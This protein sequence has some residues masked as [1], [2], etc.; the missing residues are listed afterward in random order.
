[1]SWSLPSRARVCAQGLVVALAAAA[2]LTALAAPASAAVALHAQ[3]RHNIAPRPN[4]MVPCVEQG[5]QSDAC[6]SESVAA[7]EH[8]R[9]REGLPDPALHL[10]RGYRSLTRAEQ[11]FV[12]IN[13]ERVD[14]GLRPI[15]GMVPSLDH[16]ATLAAVAGVDP[17]PAVAFLR[18]LGVHRYRS[19]FARDYGALA[20]DY[21]WLYYDGFSSGAMQNVFCAYP[22]AA[23]C[24]SHRAGILDPFDGLP[25][26]LAGAGA[27]PGIYGSTWMTAVLTGGY[28]AAP[29]FVYTWRQALAH[30]AGQRRGR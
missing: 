27:A 9:R 10:P 19:V 22:G 13:L 1:M 3:H 4:F 28:G 7:I 25:L 18:G 23:G 2:T 14:R 6:I 24:W 12:V 21:V 26:L 29:R 30:G 11:L 15:A 16:A 17:S 20:A 5:A 8:A